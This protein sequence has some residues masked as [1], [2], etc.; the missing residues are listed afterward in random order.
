MR[1]ALLVAMSSM[2]ALAGCAS[3]DPPVALDEGSLALLTGTWAGTLERRARLRTLELDTPVTLEVRDGKPPRAKFTLGTGTTWETSIEV[4]G[5]TILMGF[6]KAV[7]EFTLKRDLGGAL[8]IETSYTN[9]WEGW[10]QRN[11]IVL[12]K[13]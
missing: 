5:G 13:K 8:R 7:R 10:P 3:L 6:D 11:R 4:R 2:M 1:V 12:E 9:Q